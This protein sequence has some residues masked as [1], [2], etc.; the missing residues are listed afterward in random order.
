MSFRLYVRMAQF[1][2]DRLE[3]VDA[4][5]TPFDPRDVQVDL[6]ADTD[7]LAT[8]HWQVQAE[9]GL[10]IK[11]F[12]VEICPDPLRSDGNS[13][14]PEGGF[15]LTWPGFYRSLQPL[16]ARLGSDDALCITAL[17]EGAADHEIY[18]VDAA[19][20][21]IPETRQSAYAPQGTAFIGP[22]IY[23]LR[24]TGEVTLRNMRVFAVGTKSVLS[25][26]PLA[27]VAPAL[28]GIPEYSVQSYLG[29][30][31]GVEDALAC[32]LA[33]DSL[34]RANTTA[35]ASAILDH[36]VHR[37]KPSEVAD[38]VRN[39][40]VFQKIRDNFNDI[41]ADPGWQYGTEIQYG[42]VQRSC[43]VK[44]VQ[45]LI[46]SGPIAATTLGHA[47]TIPVPRPFRVL[48]SLQEVYTFVDAHGELPY[49]VI[50]VNAHHA[51]LNK[52]EPRST[53]LACLTFGTTVPEAIVRATGLRGPVTRDGPASANLNVSLDR[54]SAA[55]SSFVDLSDGHD[56]FIRDPRE[57]PQGRLVNFLGAGNPED[58]TERGRPTFT[59]GHI[60]LPLEAP[61]LRSIRLYCRDVFG[62]W[63]P[64]A[65][66]KCL[67]EPYPVQAPGWGPLQVDYL[68]DGTL[69]LRADLDW[70][71][72]K[73]RPYEIRVGL[74]ILT[75][76]DAGQVP[77][78]GDGVRLP[79]SAP[80]PLAITF[81]GDR[82]VLPVNIPA[83]WS[84]STLPGYV[85]D[86]VPKG[87]STP[88]AASDFRRY[89]L[90]I[91]LGQA[92]ALFGQEAA[93][94]VAVVADAW[95]VVSG[96]TQD[97]RSKEVAA[98]HVLHDPRPPTLGGSRWRLE[99]ASRVDGANRA[100]AFVD[101][102]TMADRRVAGF[103]LWRA[104]ESAI[105]DLGI[106]ETFEDVA[107]AEA[108]LAELLAERDMALRLA[109]IQ[110]LIEPHLHKRE[111]LRAFIDL[112]EVDST[113]M[114]E[115][116]TE[117]VIPGTQS[118]LEFVM[119]TAVSKANVPSDKIEL[120]DLR[121]VAV[122]AERARKRP[123]LRV[124]RPNTGS[125]FAKAGLVVVAVGAQEPFS[126]DDVRVYWDSDPD[127]QT[128]DEILHPIMPVSELSLRQ[129]VNYVA[130]ADLVLNRLPVAHWRYFALKP[131]PSWSVHNFTAD[132]R[133]AGSTLPAG[134]IASPRADLQKID[135]VP[136][137]GPMLRLIEDGNAGGRRNLTV[138]LTNI[139]E[140]IVPGLAE[141]MVQLEVL[142]N[143]A[144][145]PS[146]TPTSMRDLI[147]GGIVIPLGSDQILA[148]CAAGSGRLVIDA[149]QGESGRVLRLAGS[150]PI[151]RMDVLVIPV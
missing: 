70:D 110:G 135:L 67:L 63:R 128:A 73:R 76:M 50:R 71:W 52:G 59:V 111:F 56:N 22:G 84:V 45:M 32:R 83:G 77:H 8:L 49:P 87:A 86:D 91:S 82:P 147:A 53:Q 149:P 129:V 133:P 54:A 113:I 75:N 80:V 62:R 55:L 21:E 90:R 43:P 117:I 106:T 44:Q 9:A 119:V 66:A 18:A 65:S 120:P 100:H 137:G 16:L 93:R 108:Y 145:A 143:A 105:C 35:P 141:C 96:R 13:Q 5:G 150:D 42:V 92:E 46:A 144:N 139:F 118:G 57:D 25:F 88:P 97:R 69:E 127:S 136:S 15:R 148:K 114:R 107:D 123:H 6:P 142:A 61:T 95:E 134:E 146:G 2:L 12:E 78:P 58:R 34:A 130:G 85:S 7:H 126:S 81:D 79:S 104:H 1:P 64:A 112:F 121:A 10:P 103:Y 89:R 40:D 11:P 140:R 28:D 125:A 39:S 99:W 26:K 4:P 151:G 122:P 20:E 115:G 24:A 14:S 102:T 94:I 131:Q 37:E 17:L 132:L 124:L 60:D 47:V 72:S 138:E 48:E 23:G 51:D 41:L 36:E 101:P 68:A 109:M 74:K 31:Y 33:M 27:T 29:R 19:G 38:Q 116:P 30:D 98:S 3:R